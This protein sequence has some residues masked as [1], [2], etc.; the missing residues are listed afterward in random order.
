MLGMS[1]VQAIVGVQPLLLPSKTPSSNILD[2]KRRLTWMRQ[3]RDSAICAINQ[4]TAN[5]P[6]LPIKEGD[7]IWL[8]STNL[9]LTAGTWKLTPGRQ[10]PFCVVKQMTPV[11]YK[12]N[13]PLSYKLNLSL[14]WNVHDIFHALLLHPYRET[15]AHGPNFYQPPPDLIKGQEHLKVKTILNHWRIRWRK[16]LQY[17]IKWK[18]YPMADNS[19]ESID[20]V[21]APDL[22]STYHKKHPLDLLKRQAAATLSTLSSPTSSAQ[23]LQW[24]PLL[25]PLILSTPHWDYLPQSCCHPFRDLHPLTLSVP[26]SVH[27]L[28][29]PWMYSK[30]WLPV[31]SAS[32]PNASARIKPSLKPTR[33][34]TLWVLFEHIPF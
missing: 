25:P 3:F 10:G 20:D 2:V 33:T 31:L 1:P 28:T 21:F 5:P 22:I 29:Y 24:P 6:S 14:S 32:Q 34:G 11:L 26:S 16:A 7:N 13:L 4:L 15:E 12:L 23:Q 18:G 30:T 17:L 27:T 8:E 9:P 19:W